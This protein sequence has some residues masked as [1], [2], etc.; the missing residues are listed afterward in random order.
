MFL[1]KFFKSRV[2][3]ATKDSI[4]TPHDHEMLVQ[5]FQTVYG[6]TPNHDQMKVLNHMAQ[7]SFDNQSIFRVIINGF[8]HQVSSTPFTVRLQ[9]HDI[10]IINLNGFQ[11]AVDRVD[12]SV[13]TPI[14]SGIYEPHLVKFYHDHVKSGMSVVDIG[15]NIGF[16]SMLSAHLVG[17]TGNVSSFEPNSENCRL[18]ELSAN[19]NGLKN[20]KLF[21]FALSNEIGHALFT[22]HIGTNGGLIPDT[23]EMLTNPNCIVVPIMRL[24]DIMM[25]PVDFIKIDVEGAEGLV[26][27]GATGLIEK[28]RPV[29]TSE[30]SLEMLARVSSNNGNE[31]L[32]YF[33]SIRYNV[34]IINRETYNLD[35]IT[36]LDAFID[37]YGELTRIED[38]AFIPQESSSL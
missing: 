34:Y 7:S 21:P 36:D 18:I 28:H 1:K 16:Y 27:E 26:I 2:E 30:F 23:E 15:A 10:Q 20:F 13:S 32:Q 22:T 31:Y 19:K 11:L 17:D 5:I 4:V 38:L 25:K 29:V 3:E 35:L 6:I 9:K 24:D 33:N 12:P 8:D 37:N 14:I